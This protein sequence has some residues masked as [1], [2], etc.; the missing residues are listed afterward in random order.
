MV[1][2]PEITNEYVD[3]RGLRFAASVA[4]PSAAK[5]SFTVD[6]RASLFG[7]FDGIGGD[8]VSTALADRLLPTVLSLF[9]P[10]H[11]SGYKNCFEEAFSRLEK[12][13]EKGNAHKRC[14]M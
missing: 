2:L 13:L 7:V 9:E 3:A 6:K 1:H 5:V 12:E 10:D 8:F 4:A 11:L 14:Q